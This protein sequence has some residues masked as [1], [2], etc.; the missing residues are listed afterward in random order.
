MADHERTGFRPV[1]PKVR[2]PELERSILT[3][4]EEANVFPRSLAQRESAPEW[5]F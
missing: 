5:V 3:F 1:D 4:W 2:F